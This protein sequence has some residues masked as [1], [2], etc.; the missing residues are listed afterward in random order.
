MK[1]LEGR[2][3]QQGEHGPPPLVA[4]A[5]GAIAKTTR[6][7]L[8]KLDAAIAAK[9]KANPQF[10]RRAEIIDSVPGLGEQAVAGLIAWAP[11]L[12]RVTN[13]AAAALVGVAPY[14]DD[15]GERKGLRS[16]KG[17]R[18]GGAPEPAIT[19]HRKLQVLP[20]FAWEDGRLSSLA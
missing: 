14:D 8:R 19:G 7:E 18:R 15:S 1:D 6:A 16:I 17:G 2:I 9:I 13:E 11:E 3:D 10:A 12:G 4:K 5:L 20:R